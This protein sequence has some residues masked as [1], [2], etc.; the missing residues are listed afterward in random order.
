MLLMIANSALMVDHFQSANSLID[1]LANDF[2]FEP[3][4]QLYRMKLLTLQAE[5]YR[6]YTQ[7]KIKKHLPSGDVFEHNST[8]P[9]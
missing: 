3:S 1:T 9:I 4:V 5:A 2:A 6:F 8:R 7:L